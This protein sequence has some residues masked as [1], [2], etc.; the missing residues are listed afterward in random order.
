[1]PI[2]PASRNKKAAKEALANV[3][4]PI[5]VHSKL[6]AVSEETRQPISYLASQAVLQWL[7]RTLR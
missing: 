3:A 4:L 5:S 1:M 6:K 2:S 7:A